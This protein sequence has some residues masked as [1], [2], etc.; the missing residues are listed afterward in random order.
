VRRNEASA[1]DNA[2]NQES[3]KWQVKIADKDAEIVQ[4]LKQL[5]AFQASLGEGK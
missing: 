5:A 3:G 1:L 4:P 2:R